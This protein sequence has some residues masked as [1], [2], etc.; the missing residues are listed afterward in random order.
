MFRYFL[1]TLKIA[2]F[3]LLL[4]VQI[5]G[6]MPIRLFDCLFL[7]FHISDLQIYCAQSLTFVILF[8][9]AF[10]YVGLLLLNLSLCL[11]CILKLH[12][13]VLRILLLFFLVLL[14][15]LYC[16][17]HP[18]INNFLMFR[19]FFLFFRLLLLNII[20]SL[21]FLLLDCLTLMLL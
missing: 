17:S 4:D 11:V 3:L 20:F 5:L 2:F 12:S 8:D 19:F 7:L 13:L 10:L 9:G 21:F 16:F 1:V 14:L 6:Y 15:Y 18:Y